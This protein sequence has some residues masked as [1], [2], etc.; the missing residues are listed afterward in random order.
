M[1][2]ALS[3]LPPLKSMFRR[4]GDHALDLLFPPRCAS[5]SADLGPHHQGAQ[6]CDSCRNQL[7]LIAEPTCRRCAAPVPATNGVELDCSHCRRDRLWFDR[8][9]ALG[10]YEGFLR[11]LVLRMKT[12]PSGLL[13]RA[14]VDLAVEQQS[15]RLE[16]LGIQI[17]TPSPVHAQREWQRGAN[18]PALLCRAVARQMDWESDAR[19]L[20][21]T[22]NGSP[23]AG[24]S[25]RGRF[26][27]VRGE[28]VL[29]KRRTVAGA[30]VLLVDDVLTT[31]ATSS[32]AARVLK[33]AGAAGVTVFVI[34]RTNVG[35]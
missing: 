35:L 11:E 3:S 21:R 34:A 6:F 13:A 5:C 22:G 28:M 14:L 16:K 32:E 1:S 8:T 29:G 33:R 23:Q 20:R 26:R 4:V 27:N 15:L 30:S 10:W 17:A 7:R 9:V 2:P 12:E 18:P 24:L 25:R 19:L 31:G